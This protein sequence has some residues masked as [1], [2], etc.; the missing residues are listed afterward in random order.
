MYLGGEGTIKKIAGVAKECAIKYFYKT[1]I[2][3]PFRVYIV[4]R[5]VRHSLSESNRIHK[6]YSQGY[7]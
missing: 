1:L 3:M 4:L 5:F 7:I 2:V 6:L